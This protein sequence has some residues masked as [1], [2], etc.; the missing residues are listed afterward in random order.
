MSCFISNLPNNILEEIFCKL[1]ITN[2]IQCRFVC[3]SW[4]HILGSPHFSKLQHQL[5][6]TV[7]CVEEIKKFNR[8]PSKEEYKRNIRWFEFKEKPSFI[9]L[10]G[11][12]NIVPKS[13]DSSFQFRFINSCNG[14]VCVL[15]VPSYHIFPNAVFISIANPVTGE[16]MHLP[17]LN[18]G[19]CL[20]WYL[21][22]LGFSPKT[23]QFKAVRVSSEGQDCQAEVCTIGTISWRSIEAPLQ[24]HDYFTQNNHDLRFKSVV[25]ANG[26]LHWLVK[27]TELQ[28]I[29]IWV[30]DLD[31]EKFRQ[32][33]APPPFR[34]EFE[35]AGMIGACTYK[36]TL[37]VWASRT[38]LEVWQMKEYGVAESWTKILFIKE[39]YAVLEPFIFLK[40]GDIVLL[41]CQD[42]YSYNP[43]KEKFTRL[44]DRGN[45]FQNSATLIDGANGYDTVIKY[46]Y[47]WFVHKPS[48]VSL[49]DT[50]AQDN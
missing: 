20:N 24:L 26:S 2:L 49:K 37:L 39:R 16:S 9:N 46:E 29:E 6:D 34:E 10:E 42:L 21:C 43:D 12:C 36:D 30:F 4:K 47:R 1:P 45:P 41:R 17:P 15:A 11:N 5:T 28:S 50:V 44:T 35:N 18:K 19:R 14:L 38:F 13:S 25:F 3:K 32:M 40:N 8:Y 22:G 33:A 23:N 7:F 48:F 27:R 31:T